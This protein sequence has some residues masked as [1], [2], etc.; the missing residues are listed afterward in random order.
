[1]AEVALHLDA[2]WDYESAFAWYW[3]RS[4]RA[5]VGLEKAFELAIAFIGLHPEAS[6]LCDERHRYRSL[7][8]YPYGIVYRMIGDAIRVV[9]VPHDKQLPGFWIK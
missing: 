1:M 2:E 9:A 8:R 7:K 5:A 4:R 3:K 6:A